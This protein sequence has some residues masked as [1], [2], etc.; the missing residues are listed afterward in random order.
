[1]KN[2]ITITKTSIKNKTL[3]TIAAIAAAVIL[4]MIF[5]L[6]GRAAGLGAATGEAFLPMHLPV[7]AAALIAGPIVGVICGAISP[8][9]SFAFTGMPA[10][11]MLPFMMLELA[12]YGFFAGI[13]KDHKM[14][15]ILKVLIVQISGRAVRALAIIA[16]LYIFGNTAFGVSAVYMNIVKGIPGIIL[17]LTLVPLFVFWVNKH[18]NEEINGNV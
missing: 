16:S 5:H 11:A 12:A 14:P 8:L 6:A 9:I 7:I 4:P 18:G 10:A 3:A 13:L 15:A 2:T 17:Q 1:M